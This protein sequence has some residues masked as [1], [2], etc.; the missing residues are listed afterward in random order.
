V[1]L[2][3]LAALSLVIWLYLFFARGDYWRVRRSLIQH[4]DPLP[5]HVIAVIPARDEA[6]HIGRAVQSLLQQSVRVHVI[7][8]DDASSDRTA[9][10]ARRAAET[11]QAAERLQVLT[12]KPL[13]SGWT[14]KL[15]AVSQGIEEALKS[16]P[17][18]LLLT[19]A[20]IMHGPSS[21]ADLLAQAQRENTDLTSLMVKLACGSVAEKL[22]IPAFVFFF[23]QLYPPAWIRDTKAQTAGA[24]GGCMLVRPLALERI[25][26][27]AAIRNEVIDDCALARAIKR[28]GG[29]IWMGLTND[30]HS[31]RPYESFGEIGR[32]ISRSAFNQLRH[33]TLLLIATILGLLLTYVLPVAALFSGNFVTAL[34]GLAA[35]LLMTISYLP[36]VRFYERS[37]LWA[38]TLPVTAVFY[39]AATVHSALRYWTGRGG[40]WKGRTQDIRE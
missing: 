14:G 40:A 30:A 34:L 10:A 25:S 17:D 15:W 27:I 35:C 24:A 7:V 31:I 22:L 23:L 2:L 11:I 16:D 20:D 21:V 36:M 28:S 13:S 39:L 1:L 37:A 18:Y 26:G 9:D 12:G 38:L 6:E 5:A 4:G 8:V 19:D 33:S 32:M 29:H 3:V